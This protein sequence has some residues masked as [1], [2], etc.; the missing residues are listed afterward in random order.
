MYESDIYGK[1]RVGEELEERKDL[2]IADMEGGRRT[3]RW[4]GV[5]VEE[6]QL[7]RVE[8]IKRLSLPI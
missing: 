2:L 8:E 4:I 5:H 7:C 3:A 6:L 1:R